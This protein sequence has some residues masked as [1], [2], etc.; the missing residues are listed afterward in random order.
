M[1]RRLVFASI[2]CAALLAV[3]GCGSSGKKHSTNVYSRGPVIDCLRGHNF[4][5]S[6]SEKDV[7]FIAWSAP[8][9]GLRAWEKGT[10][11]KVDLILAFG[12]SVA[13][14]RQTMKAIRHYALR[15]PIF[16]YRLIRANVVILWAYRPSNAHKRLLLDCLNRSV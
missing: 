4:T 16:R 9:G 10:R 1:G 5:V 2:G 15:P 3:A 6:T 14:A 8:G 12:H 11:H 13:D 7:N